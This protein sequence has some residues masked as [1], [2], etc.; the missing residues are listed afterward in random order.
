MDTDYIS[1]WAKITIQYKPTS[2]KKCHRCGGYGHNRRSCSVD[3]NELDNESE[4]YQVLVREM[5][6]KMSNEK[7]LHLLFKPRRI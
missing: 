5:L 7:K 4:E 6:V 2:L 3:M 1:E